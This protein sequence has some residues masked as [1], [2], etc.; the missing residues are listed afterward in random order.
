MRQFKKTRKFDPEGN[1]NAMGG[2]NRVGFAKG[3]IKLHSFLQ[4]KEKI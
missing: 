1:K 4:S 3:K 2:I